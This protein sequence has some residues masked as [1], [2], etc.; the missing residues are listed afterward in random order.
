MCLMNASGY[1]NGRETLHFS[2]GRLGLRQD[3]EQRQQEKDREREIREMGGAG[4]MNTRRG[5]RMIPR[6]GCERDDCGTPVKGGGRESRWGSC[7]Q[8]KGA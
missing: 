2:V 8:M 6:R 3:A 7:L 1:T 5:K 4:G